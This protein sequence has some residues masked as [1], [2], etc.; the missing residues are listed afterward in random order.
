[1]SGGRNPRGYFV[2]ASHNEASATRAAERAV[3]AGLAG[4]G[5]VVFGQIYGMGENISMPLGENFERK[6]V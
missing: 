1:M 5:N 2:V 4:S 6:N 3:K